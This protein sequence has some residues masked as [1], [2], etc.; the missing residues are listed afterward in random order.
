MTDDLAWDL[1][2]ENLCTRLIR[3]IPELEDAYR[4]EMQFRRN[5]TVSVHTTFENLLKPNI[6]NLLRSG[7]DREAPRKMFSLLESMCGD[8]DA[9]VRDVA[10]M[11][12][13]KGLESNEE[14]QELM[15][16]YLGP[17]SKRAVQ[18]LTQARNLWN[19]KVNS[20]LLEKFP[21]LEQVYREE[22]KSWRDEE[23]GAHTVYGELLNPY[24]RNLLE[25][26][27][28]PDALKRAF[29]LVEAMCGD[30]DVHVQEVAV[31]TVL[32]GLEWNSEWRE[33]MRPYLGPLSKQA[34][35]DL[36]RDWRGEVLDW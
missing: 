28:N 9:R 12:V 27:D 14:L 25:S 16:P 31:V 24:L 2:C 15:D 26:G 11:S 23:P 36:A 3:E 5:R 35:R 29:D 30:E 32:E 33:A 19:S 7:R 10:V 8:E 22:L 6:I 13:F 20:R 21:E 1:W 4:K 18:D 34:V 17:L